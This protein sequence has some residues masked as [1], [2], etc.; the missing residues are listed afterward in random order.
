MT[1]AVGELSNREIALLIWLAIFVIVVISRRDLRATLGPL[2]RMIFLSKLTLS[3]LAMVGY[4]A[5]V[6]LALLKLGF[7]EWWMLKD[8]VFWFFGSA[9]ILFLNS[10]TAV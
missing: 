6:V 4:M 1:N 9:V 5:L 7:W 3:L 10:T 8:A 2:L